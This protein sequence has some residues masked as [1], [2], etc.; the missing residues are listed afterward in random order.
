MRSSDLTNSFYHLGYPGYL[1]MQWR[2]IG[3]LISP[4]R[5][6]GYHSFMNAG[7]MLLGQK[8]AYIAPGASGMILIP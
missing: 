2:A 4:V 8:S 3:L 5:V 6:A 7:L 1:H